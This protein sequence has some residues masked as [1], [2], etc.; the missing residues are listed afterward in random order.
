MS[1]VKPIQEIRRVG[2][3]A[4]VQ[5]LGPIDASRY[6][7]SC[8]GGSGDYTKERKNLLSNDFHDVVSKIIQARQK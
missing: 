5:A 4:L 6:M 1:E 3:Q 2:Y 8:E 7:R